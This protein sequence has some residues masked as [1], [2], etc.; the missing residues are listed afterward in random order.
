MYYEPETFGMKEVPIIKIELYKNN[1]YQKTLIVDDIKDFQFYTSNGK[2]NIEFTCCI[3]EKSIWSDLICNYQFN[4]YDYFIITATTQIRSALTGKDTDLILFSQQKFNKVDIK[5]ILVV[6][7]DPASPIF[8]FY[9]TWENK[10]GN[11]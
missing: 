5:F 4:D 1:H 10:D 3:V 8:H 9:E 6:E 2:K 7:G 11:S